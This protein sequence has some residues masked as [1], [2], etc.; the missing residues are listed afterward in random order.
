MLILGRIN[1]NTI[2]RQLQVQT[3]HTFTVS[4][5][6]VIELERHIQVR[7][8]LCMRQI[9]CCARGQGLIIAFPCRIIIDDNRVINLLTVATE[10][11]QI[12][13]R[14]RPNIAGTCR[15]IIGGQNCRVVAFLAV[16][17]QH[18]FQL[19]RTL[20]VIVTVIVPIN[21]HRN[22]SHISNVG[23]LNVENL[24]LFDGCRLGIVS[25]RISVRCINDHTVN[26]R[27][28]ALRAIHIVDIQIGPR[29]RP[30][31]GLIQVDRITS[32][33]TVGI[34]NSNHAVRTVT[35]IVLIIHP[36]QLCRNGTGLGGVIQMDDVILRCRRVAACGKLRCN[37]LRNLNRV[38]HRLT[39]FIARQVLHLISPR[40]VGALCNDQ[41]LQING[42]AVTDGLIQVNTDAI[43]TDI[44][45]I[46]IVMP[47]DRE[48][49]RLGLRNVAQLDVSTVRLLKIQSADGIAISRLAIGVFM[50]VTGLITENFLF[51]AVGSDDVVA[52]QRLSVNFNDLDG[53]NQLHTG[54]T[55]SILRH[56]GEGVVPV[57]S[58]GVTGQIDTVRL[59]VNCNRSFTGS[60]SIQLQNDVRGTNVIVVL[61][62]VPVNRSRNRNRIGILGDN[63]LRDSI[64]LVA[65]STFNPAVLERTLRDKLIQVRGHCQM[66]DNLDAI[67][68]HLTQTKRIGPLTGCHRIDVIVRNRLG[69]D[70]LVLPSIKIIVPL[71]SHQLNTHI[72]RALT[73]TVVLILPDDRN[74]NLDFIV[75]M[76]QTHIR[77][78]GICQLFGILAIDSRR[79]R[80][81]VFGKR[82]SR[83]VSCDFIILAVQRTL[84][85]LCRI[86]CVRD[87]VTGITVLV[88]GQILKSMRPGI[89]RGVT[90]QGHRIGFTLYTHTVC[91]QLQNDGIGPQVIVVIVIIPLNSGCD[92][93]NLNTL[94]DSHGNF[95]IVLISHIAAILLTPIILLGGLTRI[96][97]QV[98]L[99]HQIICDGISITIDRHIRELEIPLAGGHRVPGICIGSNR[100]IGNRILNPRT[101]GL[102]IHT[103]HQR[104]IHE[105]RTFTI[106]V[107]VIF[108]IDSTVYGVN[109]IGI[110]Q[111]HV[112]LCGSD[113][114]INK[115]AGGID[116]RS[117][118]I[119]QLATLTIQDANGIDNFLTRLTIRVDIQMLKG[120][121]PRCRRGVTCQQHPI[122]LTGNS[123]TVGIQLQDNTLRTE[124]VVVVIIS[125]LN[126]CCHTALISI[127]VDIHAGLGAIQ[128][129]VTNHTFCPAVTIGVIVNVTIQIRGHSQPVSNRHTVMVHIH[130]G[131]RTG[132]SISGTVAGDSLTAHHNCLILT[133]LG[134][135]LVSNQVDIHA[136]RTETILVVIVVPVDNHRNC[137]R[138]RCVSQLHTVGIR[139]GRCAIHIQHRIILHRIG[140]NLETIDDQLTLIGILLIIFKR[141]HPGVAI[142]RN[143]AHC[144]SYCD[145]TVLITA[146]RRIG[147]NQRE[148]TVAVLGIQIQHHV[149]GTHAI[150]VAVIIPLNGKD[151]VVTRQNQVMRH[152]QHALV[153]MIGVPVRIRR[154]IAAA[155]HTKVVIRHQSSIFRCPIMLRTIIVHIIQRDIIPIHRCGVSAMVRRRCHQHLTVRRLCI[156]DNSL[157]AI[158]ITVTKHTEAVIDDIGIGIAHRN[159]QIREPMMPRLIGRTAGNPGIAAKS[160]AHRRNQTDVNRLRTAAVIVVEI[161]PVDFHIIGRGL[162]VVIRIQIN[163]PMALIFPC[164]RMTFIRITG[165]SRPIIFGIAILQERCA[166]IRRIV[167]AISLTGMPSPLIV[168]CRRQNFAAILTQSPANTGPTS[169]AVHSIQQLNSITIL[170]CLSSQQTGAFTR[171]VIIDNDIF[172]FPAGIIMTARLN[173]G[174]KLSQRHAAIR[175]KEPTHKGVT[176]T[177]RRCNDRYKLIF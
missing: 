34:Q 107:V 15:C 91:K 112:R 6:I 135:P 33:N 57:I 49:H 128:I 158:G 103:S 2:S 101:R 45:T 85:H 82:M 125:P 50:Q 89:C 130:V 27:S 84:C 13:E 10:Y 40:L 170:H 152:I 174:F 132:P 29:T 48:V 37:I 93:K 98:R 46:V 11:R 35:I 12:F 16:H 126:G 156:L 23:N 173:T 148:T 104:D 146:G 26:H 71:I 164:A 18:H 175:V 102:V 97:I 154:R 149:L 145:R 24:V 59:T 129:E 162:N 131:E 54:M 120:V 5:V 51:L 63:H 116:V 78:N 83:T 163:D 176:S 36:V 165:A 140:A 67:M 143:L 133:N 157:I 114:G 161:V 115:L 113:K 160:I 109:L 30:I 110:S 74:R 100:L 123:L 61:T 7:H 166:G 96:T 58:R 122:I 41:S 43:G 119:T 90:I 92:A 94:I 72:L 144:L 147:S 127:V 64:Q 25:H 155:H 171:V 14:I 75:L 55:G 153:R 87:F 95:Q 4:I 80:S 19:L 151:D 118:V 62:V 44:V 70:F 141:I 8:C 28:T 53:I 86:N 139:A 167:L 52:I 124:T 105:I 172:S 69:S 65:I 106:T 142:I 56:T 17:Q 77:L 76:G 32:G 88:T 79:I 42:A 31:I 68:I 169:C 138:L 38:L 159:G 108:P 73:V 117:R 21:S 177:H 39:V 66:V 99:D 137:R 150:T 9:Q 3:R 22:I 168:G 81:N 60:V 1:G 47:V 136:L 20:T 134:I 111:Q 121:A